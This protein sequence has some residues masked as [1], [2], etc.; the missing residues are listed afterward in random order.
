MATPSA[1]NLS[2]PPG[3]AGAASTSAA[4][5]RTSELTRGFG[6][7]TAVNAV[8]VDIAPGEILGLVGPNGAGKTT[9]IKMLT[10]LLPPTSGRA[11]VAGY[12]V[13]VQPAR[14]RAAIGYVPQMLSADGALT[15]YENLSVTAALYAVPRGER[16]ARVAEALD[17]MG[18]G[19][20]APRLVRHYSG[21]MIRRLEIAQSILHRPVVLFMDEPTGGLDPVARRA[22]WER[23]RDLRSELG[24][25]MLITTHHMEEA[26][27]LCDRVAVMYQGK[28][29]AI[30]SPPELKA[31]VGPGATL[32]DAFIHFT[33]VQIQ[34][35]GSF[36]E[37]VRARRTA[38]R[39]S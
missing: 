35:E 25:T 28:V 30:G 26:E 15:G 27:A 18:L 10:T 17:L 31:H 1:G 4:A 34:S 21:G 33:G 38:R 20:A 7:L 32:D 39:L 9:L 3:V 8:S 29:V 5:I 14:I 37:T 11:W 22:V 6:D 19:D 12:E 23:V 2:V 16:A 24:T 36:R 13:T